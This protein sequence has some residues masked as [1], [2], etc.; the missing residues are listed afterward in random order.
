LYRYVYPGLFLIVSIVLSWL[1][2]PMLQLEG[3]QLVMVR[4][5]ILLLGAIAA[6][7]VYW[8]WS[9]QATTQ[10]PAASA[11]GNHSEL[12]SLLQAAERRLGGA[13]RKG[14]HSLQNLPLLYVLGAA[15]SAKTSV[16]LKSGLDPELLA[17][18]AYQ[19]DTVIPT[20]GAN[21]WYAQDALLVDA[22]EALR[23]GSTL[24][25]TLV[26]RTRYRLLPSVLGA[27][28]P[29]RAAVVCVSCESFFGAHAAEA[30][31]ALGRDTNATLR[32]I[33]SSLGAEL[34]VYVV[35]TKL[36]RVP[37]FAEYMR[38]LNSEEASERLGI[39]LPRDSFADG[40]YA[41]RASATLGDAL[42]RL[43][44]SLGEFRLEVLMRAST[45]DQVPLVY[46]FPRELQKLR[47]TL[48]NYLVELVRPSHL[49]ANPSLRGFYCVGLRA[50]VIEQAISA[51]AAMPRGA[52]NAADATGILSLRRIEA[53][54]AGVETPQN[55]SRR[56]AQWCFLPRLFPDVFLASQ[57]RSATALSSARVSLVRRVA[58]CTVSALLFGCVVG[59]T[60][61]YRNNARMEDAIR[62]AATS[63]PASG[64]T[65]VLAPESQLT[66][67]DHL[68]LALLQLEQFDR[69]GAPLMY[70]WGLYR[71]DS[72][73]AVTRRL[74]FER[75]RYLLL[76]STQANLRTS[77]GALPGTA[78]ANA[79]YL[80]AYHPLRAYL[81][82]TSS[83]QYS[84]EAFLAP[85][86]SHFWLNGQHTESDRQAQLADQQFRFFANELRAAPLYD[87]APDI[88]VVTHARGYLNS[89]GSFDRVYQN[90][91]EAANQTS[92]AIDFNHL[93][94]GSAA[95]IVETHIVPG[96]FSRAG[97]MFM[98]RA[99]QHPEQYFAGEPWV[100][101]DQASISAQGETLAQMLQ[102]R[103]LSDFREQ[104]LLYLRSASVVRYRNLSDARQKLQSLSAPTSA[105]LALISTASTNTAAAG[106]ALAHEFQPAQQ[107]VPA[108][109]TD[110]LIAPGNT[111][112][113]NGL[114]GLQG[115]VSQYSQDPSSANNPTAAQPVIAAAVSAHAAVSQTAQAFDIDPSEHVGDTIT[116]LMQ[117]PITSVEDAIRGAAPEQVNLA[118]RAFCA[119][120][121]PMLSKFPFDRNASV[122]ATP[123]E[124]TAALKP[125]TGALWQFYEANLKS[126]V[127]QQGGHWAAA[128]TA[129]LKPTAQFLQFFNRAAALSDA[130]FA[131]GAITPT[132]SLTA[133]LPPS[134]GIQS[135]TLE[136]DAQRLSGSDVTKPFNWS[137]QN[138]QQ[139]QLIASY[140]SNN[141]PLKFSGNWSLFHLVDRGRVEQAGNPLRLAYP[142]EIAGTPIVVNGTALTERIELS[143][144]AAGIL[145]PGSL[146]G[147]HCVAQVAH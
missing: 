89:F 34:P 60:L 72:L 73:L 43:F 100:L 17:G 48:T 57:E 117:E 3:L 66:N 99:M 14:R 95:T 127:V 129:A 85:V 40:P 11:V 49:N 104:W 142:L 121:A 18:Q 97:F 125:A 42:D 120:F 94:P 10:D 63:L 77:L 61:S 80:A 119:S 4:T 29:L 107:L 2:G 28:R 1:A 118:G 7:C 55:V 6:F 27:K 36:D 112:Y 19:G 58:L 113:V 46:Q 96:A 137:A 146:S 83:H 51:P 139:A 101:G 62:E 90:V 98:Q 102:T 68:R 92:P 76:A 143:G 21:L 93:F 37:G 41:E 128:P 133:H 111:T 106:G 47:D 147:L 86:L 130:L 108:N 75:F 114:I 26:R 110:R 126:L 145:A 5:V 81:I 30:A 134:P 135:V 82:T 79:D 52:Q 24:W 70:R 132:L 9:R 32:R 23:P 124:V 20:R 74:Y 87:I 45:A 69:D 56:V 140:G 115:A 22:G 123:A 8:F 67:L 103:Y 71:G 138:S 109:L 88:P 122:E 12:T 50:Q 16:I 33:A 53:A 131:N 64:S 54:G 44:F 59:M 91:L 136:L 144:P 105:L 38:H 31:V 39:L 15:N 13:Q 84:T 65:V 25:S 141:L 116:K 35:L 78:P